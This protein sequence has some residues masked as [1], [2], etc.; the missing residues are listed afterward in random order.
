[1]E[2]GAGPPHPPPHWGRPAMNIPLFYFYTYIADLCSCRRSKSRQ[3]PPR[4]RGGLLLAWLQFIFSYHFVLA[5]P[6]FYQFSKKENILQINITR[7]SLGLESIRPSSIFFCMDGTGR[8]PAGLPLYSSRRGHRHGRLPYFCGQVA[9]SQT[10]PK[11]HLHR[12]CSAIGT[13]R[14]KSITA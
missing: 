3:P 11:V 7:H 14:S 9:M 4:A 2:Y 13:P 12:P 10:S 6:T 1:M 5:T 8:I